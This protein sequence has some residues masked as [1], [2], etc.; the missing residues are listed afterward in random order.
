M[1]QIKDLSPW[2]CCGAYNLYIV[3][4]TERFRITPRTGILYGSIPRKT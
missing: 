1:M 4:Y 3:C 2:G